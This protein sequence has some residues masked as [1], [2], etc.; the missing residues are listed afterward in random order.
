MLLLQC[1][2]TGCYALTQAYYQN[3]LLNS[4]RPVIDVLSDPSTPPAMR[5]KLRFVQGIL[6]FAKKEG[7]SP[8]DLYTYY[9]P[10]DRDFI[11]CLV[12][13]AYPDRLEWL[14]HWFP[15]VGRVPYLGFFSIKDCNAKADALK[16]Q[17][18]DVAIGAADAFSSLGWFND[19]IYSSM[20]KRD[21]LDLA[22]LLFHE[23]THHIFWLS[24]QVDFDENL[25]EFVADELVF[26]YFRVNGE[27]TVLSQYNAL[28]NDLK[29]YRLW[30][31]DLHEDLSLLYA[32][33][34]T[35]VARQNLMENKRKVFESFCNKRK[36]HFV[37]DR[38][39]FI[40]K[41]EWNNA[42]VMAASLYQAGNER[43]VR[44]YRCFKRDS[45]MDFIHSLRQR[46]KDF[47]DPY[48]AV[49]SYCKALENG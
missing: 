1:G 41:R 9:V 35:P 43:F 11:T 21:N 32:S 5:D 23:M 12:Q 19:P 34:V 49:D 33:S 25:A 31:R 37:T 14:T 46:V 28:Q 40:D 7:L 45:M 20:L 4:R 24:D 15:F 18:F 6:K 42:Y 17:G 8:G 10:I 26:K 16:N 48:Q 3:N 39:K 30:L 36:P 47:A 22:H 13:A 29:A 27:E 38:F 44:A 2:V